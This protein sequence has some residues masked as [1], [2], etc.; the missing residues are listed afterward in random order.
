M[1]EVI[2][3]RVVEMRFDNSQF[4]SNVRESLKTIDNLKSSLNFEGSV[5]G[6]DKLKVDI[7][8]S[9]AIH[10]LNAISDAASDCDLS[11]LNN[12]AESVKLSF[13]ALEVVAVTALG[14]IASAAIDAGANAVK[15]FA[16]QPI[17]DGFSEYNQQLKSTRVI[18]SNTGQSL[19]EV[20][21]VLD[22]L[23]KYADKTIYSFGDMTQA[24]GYFTSALGENSAEAAAMIAKGVSNWAASTGQGNEVA[25]RVMYQI[26]Q[27]LSTGSFRLMDWKSIENTGAMAGAVYQKYFLETASEM[28]GKSVEELMVDKKGDPVS[29]FRESLQSG[30]LTNEVFLETMAKFANVTDILNENGERAFQW[31]EDA[32]TKVLTFSDLMDTI[33]EQLGTG[34]GDTWKIV[35]GTF[36]DSMKFFT[37]ISGRIGNFITEMNDARNAIFSR[38]AE[39]GGR[40]LLFGVSEEDVGAVGKALDG[41][42]EILSQIQGAFIDVFGTEFLADLLYGATEAISHVANAFERLSHLTFIHTALRSVLSVLRSIFNIIKDIYKIVEP[43][44]SLA[45]KG[46]EHVLTGLS[47]IAEVVANIIDKISIKFSSLAEKITA[48][49]Q[50]ASNFISSTF[51]SALDFVSQKIASMWDFLKQFDFLGIMPKNLEEDFVSTSDAIDGSIEK[52]G[53]A[54]DGF[55]NVRERLKKLG[56]EINSEAD[57]KGNGWQNILWNAINEDKKKQH[58]AVELWEEFN[59]NDPDDIQKE[60]LDAAVNNGYFD[61]G[62]Y[63][64][65]SDIWQEWVGVGQHASE[66][67]K[68]VSKN[69]ETVETKSKNVNTNLK[70]VNETLEQSAESG[71]KVSL[72]LS[73]GD[74]EKTVVKAA[75]TADDRIDHV[76]K[77]LAD[78]GIV[79]EGDARLINSAWQDILWAAMDESKRQQHF[80]S[81]LW[82][83]LDE[84]QKKVWLDAADYNG[85]YEPGKR[86]E[87]RDIW[88]ELNELGKYSSESTEATADNI[89]DVSGSLETIEKKSREVTGTWWD[90]ISEAD[91]KRYFAE[92]YWDELTEEQREGWKQYALGL[93]LFTKEELDQLEGTEKSIDNLLDDRDRLVNKK[94]AEADAWWNLISEDNKKQ[95][96]AGQFWDDLTDE[97]REA[98]RKRAEEYNL[99]DPEEYARLLA[100]M[101][102]AEQAAFSPENTQ[103]IEESASGLENWFNKASKIP[104]VGG[105]LE[106]IGW[107]LTKT[108]KNTKSFVS[109]VGTSFSGFFDYVKI[110]NSTDYSFSEKFGLAARYFKENVSDYL[111]QLVMKNFKTVGDALANT[112][113][114]SKLTTFTSAVK[115]RFGLFKNYVSEINQN[116]NLTF[117]EKFKLSL[118]YF[119]SNVVDYLGELVGKNLKTIGEEL[120]N[121]KIVS[122]IS[123]LVSAGKTKFTEFKEYIAD[124]NANTELTFPEKLERS[125]AFLK[126]NVVDYFLE[127]VNKNL[128]SIGIDIEQIGKDISQALSD[129]VKCVEI[130]LDKLGINTDALKKFFWNDDGTLKSIPAVIT[131]LGDK[132]EKAINSVKTKLRSIY[133]GFFPS[134]EEGMLTGPLGWLADLKGKVDDFIA[135]IFGTKEDLEKSERRGAKGGLL[136]SALG[137]LGITDS[138]SL[139]QAAGGVMS[140]LSF[141]KNVGISGKLDFGKIAIG[142]ALAAGAFT[143]LSRVDFSKLGINFKGFTDYFKD[144]EGNLLSFSEVFNKVG[145]SVSNSKFV[146]WV[147][148]TAQ[149]IGQNFSTAFGLLKEKTL[150]FREFLKVLNES[151]LSFPQKFDYAFQFFKEQF[152]IPFGELA[153]KNL[154]T[155]GIDIDAFVNFFKNNEGNWLSIGDI[156]KKVGA[157]IHDAFSELKAKFEQSKFGT[158]ISDKLEWVKGKFSGVSEWLGDL[159]K[160]I[161]RYVVP[162]LAGAGIAFVISR[163]GQLFDFVVSI[164]QMFSGRTPGDRAE[165]FATKT[166]ALAG[167]V[168]EIAISVMMIAGT[169]AGLSLLNQDDLARASESLSAI[170]YAITTFTG[171]FGIMAAINSRGREESKKAATAVLEIAGSIFLI[172]TAF[173]IITTI[174]LDWKLV[175]Y[176]V[177]LGALMA[178]T[179][180]LGH[181]APKIEGSVSSFLG[182]IGIATAVLEMVGALYLVQLML[183]SHQGVG[184]A[185]VTLYGLV[186]A[187]ALLCLAAKGVNWKAGLG[188]VLMANSV[189]TMISAL[190]RVVD[191]DILEKIREKPWESLLKIGGVL[192]A[193]WAL[194][195]IN[196][197]AGG[198]KAGMNLLGVAAS[199]WVLV[200]AMEQIAEI[201]TDKLLPALG[202]VVALSIVMG[203]IMVAYAAWN[204]G[205]KTSLGSMIATTVQLYAVVIGVLL[206]C[207]AVAV[208]SGIDQTSLITA[209]SV[210]GGLTLVVG[211]IAVLLTRFGVFSELRK[212]MAMLAS[213][214]AVAA[215]MGGLIWALDHFIPDKSNLL[216]ITEAVGGLTAV[217]GVFALLFGIIKTKYRDLGS[218]AV[219]LLEMSGVVA[220]I[221]AVLTIMAR[222]FPSDMDSGKIWSITGSIAALT[223]LIGFLSWIFGS[224]V[225]VDF[226]QA[227]KA[228]GAMALFGVVIE[229]LFLAASLIVNWQGAE[230]IDKVVSTVERIGSGLAKMFNSVISS[231]GKLSWEQLAAV[232]VGA[233][234]ALVIIAKLGPDIAVGLGAI[235]LVVGLI[236]DILLGFMIFFFDGKNGENANTIM[237]KIVPTMERIGKGL[238]KMFNGLTTSMGKCSWNQLAKT[239]VAFAVGSAAFAVFGTALEVVAIIMVGLFDLTLP[240]FEKFVDDGLPVLEKLAG[241]IIRIASIIMEGVVANLETV[242]QCLRDFTNFAVNDFDAAKVGEAVAIAG[243]LAE[244]IGA[245]VGDGFL[246]MLGKFIGEEL[247]GEANRAA[248]Q[249]NARCLTGVL[250]D[251]KTNVSSWTPVEFEKTRSATD[252]AGQLIEVCNA[253]TGTGFVDAFKNFL[254]N[255][256]FGATNRGSF[257]ANMQAIGEALRTFCTEIDSIPTID[258]V[259]AGSAVTISG[260]MIELVKKFSP[261]GAGEAVMQWFSSTDFSAETFKKNIENLSDAVSVFCAKVED[262]KIPTGYDTKFQ[263]IDKLIEFV[264]KMPELSD[265]SGKMDISEFGTSIKTFCDEFKTAMTSL[266]DTLSKSEIKDYDGKVE[267]INDLIELSAKLP[268]AASAMGQIVGYDVTQTLGQFGT[269]ISTFGTNL[270]NFAT[271]M[272]GVSPIED[273]D[274]KKTIIS[275]LIEFANMLPKDSSEWEKEVGYGFQMDF[276]AFGADIEAFAESF[277]NV[278]TK[279]NEITITGNTTTKFE[280]MTSMIGQLARLAKKLPQSFS[281]ADA[282]GNSNMITSTFTQTFSEFMD[283]IVGKKN[284]LLNKVGDVY[285]KLDAIGPFEG[286]RENTLKTLVGKDGMLQQL[287]EFAK[288]LPDVSKDTTTLSTFGQ[289]ILTL[290]IHMSDAVANLNGTNSEGKYVFDPQPLEDLAKGVKGVISAFEGITSEELGNISSILESISKMKSS[291][292]KTFGEQL[293]DN[294]LGSLFSIPQTTIE[295]A[296]TNATGIGDVIHDLS[297]FGDLIKQ[298]APEGGLNMESITQL[299]GSIGADGKA[300]GGALSLIPTSLSQ[301]T[302][303]MP[304]EADITTAINPLTTMFSSFKEGSFDFSGLSPLFGTFSNGQF[305]D[306]GILQAMPAEIQ[307]YINAMTGGA[308]GGFDITA[309]NQ[310]ITDLA[311]GVSEAGSI[312]PELATNFNDTL[313]AFANN[314]IQSYVD[315]F[316]SDDVTTKLTAA[317]QTIVSK[318][319]DGI[320][321]AITTVPNAVRTASEAVAKTIVDIL[322]GNPNNPYNTPGTPIL[323]KTANGITSALG[324]SAQSLRNAV[325]GVVKFI[326]NILSGNESDMPYKAPGYSIITKTA[327]GINSA[328]RTS[329]YQLRNA[330]NGIVKVI[331]DT[332]SGYYNEY[333]KAGESVISGFVA[334]MSNTS[335]VYMSSYNL[336]SMA[337]NGLKYAIDSNSPS[338]EAMKYGQYFGEGFGI[339]IDSYGQI[340]KSTSEEI[341][342]EALFGLSSY[343]SKIY[344]LLDSDL[345]VTPRITPVLDL[346]EIQNG[347]GF[348]DAMFSR[349]HA[350]STNMEVTEALRARSEAMTPVNSTTDNSRNFGGFTF[351][352]YTQGTDA[353]AIARQIGEEV[354]RRLRATGSYVR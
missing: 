207:A 27:A 143:L 153:K 321:T 144:G 60:W 124:L 128:K 10:G 127:L 304:K 337:I 159:S 36:E 190:E 13:S 64:E 146:N 89:S 28:Y 80:A 262:W 140:A 283:E 353:T 184:W 294:F 265:V 33:R 329:S 301:F 4:E 339:G 308:E 335:S 142:V 78:L 112:S 58:Y 62:V 293:V 242:I 109:A 227:R 312:T 197:A 217:V 47:Q 147:G 16:I 101:N 2:D 72:S 25:K 130:T 241:G 343:V 97:Q 131:D 240:L 135:S 155:V 286:D 84:D 93:G 117:P 350:Y 351:N 194:A 229:G 48:P 158:W 81:Q 99:Y 56:I 260:K 183:E 157:K 332:L 352:I 327:D 91:K 268:P 234:A 125:V 192:V 299:F 276:E 94:R 206:L 178:A 65:L 77:R 103:E 236:S 163:V 273:W 114:V 96:F 275:Q 200:Q 19:A 326:V 37:G 291:D 17:T 179:V 319:G 181:F 221:A 169:I 230:T 82:N 244:V 310:V 61:P 210:V 102:A 279:I 75:N 137:T 46:V 6:L 281:E 175:G 278:V 40:N 277:K 132:I 316:N 113:I 43:F 126:T 209:G 285:K 322:S 338:K 50:V 287:S 74:A 307:E 226:R 255:E 150:Y 69:L 176:F 328:L 247:F 68:D 134:T 317:G 318:T 205:N 344:D 138:S 41:V 289:E 167:I 100:E 223:G 67:V 214:I 222:N 174:P 92:Q 87:L 187:F 38:W 63:E 258:L 108:V 292:G 7:D 323:N 243:Q 35:F 309:A 51:G 171:V 145:Q 31:M 204:K 231:L 196:N 9:G 23:N 39:K 348:I 212:S 30:W 70:E 180:A 57:L 211:A 324:N 253:F 26:S 148:N 106:K 185:I 21:A 49:F 98:W 105:F 233:A 341:G 168:K 288:N 20:T 224:V 264:G 305:D 111:G 156:I 119:K 254:M 107:A 225:K 76:K 345:D 11:A 302:T 296:K 303:D 18:T 166:Q 270:S 336:G 122:N 320:N 346:S 334:G 173:K 269:D 149:L 172:A 110:L 29:S 162:V 32:A 45:F 73:L 71:H 295:G 300:S 198:G 54:V 79:V 95:Y 154:K 199:V 333:V 120:S 15:A 116:A 232:F 177:V 314:G 118:D 249:E 85:F 24:M 271:A 88:Q 263:I 272:N 42:L 215:L 274:T 188:L 248:F 354:N 235:M 246:D 3:S 218:V 115:D 315:A 66:S 152:V 139:I 201:P 266:N 133:E 1:S 220:L 347:A 252:I 191:S 182:M 238:A 311:S 14:K 161:S 202:V 267:V 340:I 216:T 261:E 219:I 257:T 193:L 53:K 136:Q 104:V 208:L 164:G 195:R 170:I 123:S 228:A 290:S 141:G 160:N 5:K 55:E 239:L 251:F 259:K 8:A 189:R 121:N 165:A 83:D 213:V 282:S 342:S 325:K 151:D 306:T 250:T 298:I 129:A 59:K 186:G 12:S 284:S 297:G 44:L 203:G 330:A 280:Q 22:D 237:N 52:A 90:L 245:F 331:L 349:R 313:T 34:W 256:W 86:E